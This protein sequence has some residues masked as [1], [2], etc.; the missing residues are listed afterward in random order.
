MTAAAE[1]LIAQ[2]LVDRTKVGLVGFS[3]NGWYAEYSLTHSGFPFAAA[4]AADN[5]DPSYSATMLFSHFENAAA[6]NG[7]S[8]FGEGLQKWLDKAP[9]FNV[10]RI[11]APLLKI[12]QS[13][14][15]LLGVL[16]HWELVSRMRYL[17]KPL[18][19]YVMPDVPEHG[20]H[21]TQN[22]GQI[23][24]VQQRA[25]DWFD[26]WLNGYEDPDPRKAEQYAN[27]RKFRARSGS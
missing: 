2:G 27:W 22:P 17:K 26:F 23:T 14:G 5:W 18:E 9:G 6:V 16:S 10:D 20:A 25:V 21:N 12:E 1:Y 8:P 11:E 4:I 19:F 24:A 3:R 13:T 7:A 15:G